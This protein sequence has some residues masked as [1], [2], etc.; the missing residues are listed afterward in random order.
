MRE[1]Y[2]RLYTEFM[3]LLGRENPGVRD[4]IARQVEFRGQLY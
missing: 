2:Q 1:Y 3:E 4:S